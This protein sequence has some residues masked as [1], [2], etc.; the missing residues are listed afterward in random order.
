MGVFSSEVA[1]FRRTVLGCLEHDIRHQLRAVA[2]GR[3]LAEIGIHLRACAV[4]ERHGLAWQRHVLFERCIREAG[5]NEQDADAEL[6]HFVV[7]RF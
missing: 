3:E 5:L 4:I 7:E 6:A 1:G 2:G